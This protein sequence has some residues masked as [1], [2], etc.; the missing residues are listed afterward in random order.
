MLSPPAS[1]ACQARG[2]VRIAADR[3]PTVRRM[4]P[5][6]AAVVVGTELTHA[7]RKNDD[8]KFCKVL[9]SGA[10]IPRSSAIQE[11]CH[12]HKRATIFARS[13]MGAIVWAITV[14]GL[15]PGLIAV[16]IN[17]ATPPTTI[18]E[19]KASNSLVATTT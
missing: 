16:T 17:K 7:G 5:A 13:V 8:L 15:I 4:V 19:I 14:R 3:S 11:H 2:A 9:I 1:R 12:M 6:Q 18:F 10:S